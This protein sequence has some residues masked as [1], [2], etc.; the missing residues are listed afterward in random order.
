MA[1]CPERLGNRTIGSPTGLTAA[2]SVELVGGATG[3]RFG[4]ALAAGDFNG[5][6]Q[7]DLT[8]GI[9]SQ[10]SATI[11]DVG[12]VQVLYGSASGLATAGAQLWTQDGFAG[13]DIA[14]HPEA[15][16]G[17]GSALAWG[18]FNG[19]GQA[20]L[21]IGVRGEDLDNPHLP[22]VHDAGAVNVLYG[23]ASVGLTA[24]GNQVW[25]QNSLGI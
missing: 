20:D 1:C 5:D 12:A 11:T 19:D 7:A 9:P 18:D 15:G 14:D 16:D 22:T 10:D 25:T 21:A 4:F 17:F 24:P 23:A 6:G 8:I 2:G 3:D 13:Q